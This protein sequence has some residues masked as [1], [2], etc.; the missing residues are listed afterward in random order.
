MS[1]LVQPCPIPHKIAAAQKLYAVRKNSPEFV[2]YLEALHHFFGLLNEQYNQRGS[3]DVMYSRKE[4]EP[5]RLIPY[6]SL[7]FSDAKSI[8][9]LY[10]PDDYV[11]ID[12]I[13]D[14]VQ[15]SKLLRTT[16]L[17]DAAQRTFKA[18]VDN[19]ASD[20]PSFPFEVIANISITTVHALSPTKPDSAFDIFDGTQLGERMEFA[21]LE[22]TSFANFGAIATYL[23]EVD[24]LFNLLMKEYTENFTFDIV[25]PKENR[26]FRL[27]TF[28]K[29]VLAENK[30]I[31]PT[32]G[33]GQANT[34]I[35]HQMTA[36]HNAYNAL[37]G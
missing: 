13:D 26:P 37:K 24:K 14:E 5:L 28:L 29:F 19:Q 21:R 16:S 33:V 31:T 9:P 25:L 23:L 20:A 15:L 34:P 18:I 22:Y 11:G 6:L 35:S 32:Y 2:K 7:V 27:I 30:G 17:M 12:D 4:E 10:Y 1:L 36:V 3:V 8:W